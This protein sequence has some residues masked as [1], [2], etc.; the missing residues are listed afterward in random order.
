MRLAVAI[1]ACL[2]ASPGLAEEVLAQK[3][4]DSAEARSEQAS[5][6][7]VS[8]P[9]QP[10]PG[11]AQ[12]EVSA[13]AEGGDFSVSAALEYR[14][15]VVVD[16]DP[17]N[18][19]HVVLAIKAEARPFEAT[20]AFVRAGLLRRFWAEVGE[21]GFFLQDLALG[22]TYSHALRLDRLRIPREL[23]LHYLG[24]VYLP[25]SRAS[26]TQSLYAAPDLR[27]TASVEVLPRLTAGLS[28]HF[29][30]RFH[31]YAE[32]AGLFG[33]MNTQYLL[34]G[35]LFAGYQVW[36]SERFGDVELE[37]SGSTTYLRKYASREAYL[38]EA[39]DAA[40]LFQQYGWGVSA[41]YRAPSRW[42]APLEGLTFSL[43]IDHGGS[44]LR[45]GIVNTFLFHRD[46]TELVA[47]LS[48]TY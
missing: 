16:P 13:V 46:E 25:T 21:S 48:G 23:S 40:P 36:S 19:R 41:T 6:E 27:G 38:S 15:L 20:T 5:D 1:A 43:G 26:L 2:A 12:A 29:Q 34:G 17:A 35:Q 18:D 10:K 37:A 30:Y 31:K 22:A 44:V 28:A 3:V 9:S 45:D 11:E 39:S 7:A 47:A 32:R 8:A 33:G 42:V 4:E 14:S 24:Q